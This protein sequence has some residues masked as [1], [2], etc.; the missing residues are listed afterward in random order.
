[1]DVIAFDEKR[2]NLAGL[3]PS[4]KELVDDLSDL[5]LADFAPFN[6]T[7]DIP[8]RLAESVRLPAIGKAGD[9]VYVRDAAIP[10]NVS[11]GGVKSFRGKLWITINVG[12]AGDGRRDPPRVAETS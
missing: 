12:P 1:V 2:T 10:L 11:V 7:I 4:I 6:Y 9:D 3:N 5:G 8:V